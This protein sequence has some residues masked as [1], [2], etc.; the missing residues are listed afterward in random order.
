MDIELTPSACARIAE[1]VAA[2]GRQGLRLSVK[3]AGCSGLEYVME[4]VDAARA[5]DLERTYD[6]F[7]LYVDADAYARAL[8]GLKLDF[9]QDLLSSAFIYDNPN[10]KGTCGCGLSF[11]V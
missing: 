8:K 9:Q 1:I 6:D 10:E 5:G 3:E 7:T 4:T 11:S 2:E